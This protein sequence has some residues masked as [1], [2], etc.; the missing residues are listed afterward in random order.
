MRQRKKLKTKE[1]D[2][3]NKFPQEAIE[4]ARR[5]LKKDTKKSRKIERKIFII[6]V[7]DSQIK[8]KCRAELAK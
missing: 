1:N 2:Y 3:L 6:E 4:K 7:E 5:K 8:K